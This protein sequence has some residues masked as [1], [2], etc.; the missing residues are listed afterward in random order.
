MCALQG[1]IE[2]DAISL[3]IA[4]LGLV[5]WATEIASMST[6]PGQRVKADAYVDDKYIG[7][8][9]KQDLECAVDAKLSHVVFVKCEEVSHHE[10]STQKKGLRVNLLV[11]RGP[12]L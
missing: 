12:H 3:I 2:G 6:T 4:V 5:V 1:A 11:C 8:H 10:L 9:S 7:T